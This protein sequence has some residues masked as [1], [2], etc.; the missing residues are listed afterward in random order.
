MTKVVDIANAQP[1][2][3]A[4]AAPIPLDADGL[5]SVP[6]PSTA[7]AAPALARRRRRGWA[8]VLGSTRTRLIVIFFALLGIFG[9]GTTVAVREILELRLSDRTEA[10]LRQEVLEVERLQQGRDPE[11]AR[12]FTSLARLFDVYHERNVPSVEE[13]FILLIG[14]EVYRDRLRSFPGHVIPPAALTTFSAFSAGRADQG[15]QLS[16]RF[17]TAHG[18]ARFRAVRMSVGQQT[19]AFVVTILPAAEQRNIRELQTWGT[20]GTIGVALLVAALAWFLVG[21]VIAPVQQLTE[22]ARSIS[23]SDLTHRIRVK[24]TSEAAEMAE[25]FN[26]MLDRLETVYR[27]QLEFLR[28]AGHE[29]RTPLTVATGH[30]EVIGEVGEEQHA[31]IRLVLDE[32]GRMTRMVEDLHSLAEADHPDFIALRAVDLD[33]LAHELIAKAGALGERHWKLDEAAEGMLVADRH[34]LLQAAL[35]LA[36]NAVKNTAAGDTI[37]IGVGVRGDEVHIWVRDTGVGIASDEQGRVLE[38]FVR[39]RDAGRRYRGA[40]LGL[41][42]VKTIAEAHGGRVAV[43]SRLGVGS[44]FT[45]VLPWVRA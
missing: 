10:A 39:G 26:D 18:E 36:D 7:Q 40:G 3:E 29:L 17:G 38:R 43:D 15:D 32:L 16:G 33:E 11:T 45:I 30:L 25:T 4:E 34:R 27:S 24:G 1:L 19:G 41:A 23:E 28:A 13:A 31:T 8:G 35:N 2:S 37:G 9:A 6:R 14:T 12:P 44:R 21:R 22:T 20:G 42:I 5:P